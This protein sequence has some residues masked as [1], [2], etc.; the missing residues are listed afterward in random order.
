[1]RRS[2][3]VRMV[4]GGLVALTVVSVAGF[5]VAQTQPATQPATPPVVQPVQ[6][7]AQPPAQPPGIEAPAVVPAV[8]PVPAQLPG[9]APPAPGLSGSTPRLSVPQIPAGPVI[10]APGP[11]PGAGS[12]LPAAGGTAQVLPPPPVI[13]LPDPTIRSLRTSGGAPGASGG[14]ITITPPPPP[15]TPLQEARQLAPAFAMPRD[16]QRLVQCYG[17]A[18]FMEAVTRVRANR[19][20]AT[21]DVRN[22][23]TELIRLQGAMQPM[24]LI[25]SDVRTER[26]FRTDY[27]AVGDRLQRELGASRNPEATLQTNLRTVQA[28]QR[29]VIRWRGDR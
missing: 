27:T 18:N 13:A 16:Y 6:P 7:P 23:V 19:P 20:G 21:A 17:T 25:A 11:A 28:C 9:L 10:P 4:T 26:R 1:M 5:A 29:D 22:L 14:G 12:P 15:M 24:V 3:R 8:A 2:G